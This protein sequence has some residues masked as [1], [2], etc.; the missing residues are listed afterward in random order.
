MFDA[1]ES[2]RVPSGG[3]Q[4]RAPLTNFWRALSTFAVVTGLAGVGCGSP[5]EDGDDAAS[6]TDTGS[7]VDGIVLEDS[8]GADA[9]ADSGPD[10]GDDVG[11][12]ATKPDAA[13]P[14]M[15]GPD[16]VGGGCPGNP[17]CT[18]IE[19]NDCD[20]SFCIDS[21]EGKVCAK[22]CVDSCEP[23]FKCTTVAGP[24]GDGQNICVAQWGKRC[25]PC[26][27]NADC[28]SIGHGDAV[29]VDQG[30]IGSFCGAGCAT[31]KD[32][33][34]GFACKESTDVTGKK[35]NQCVVTEG[36]CACS[37]AA[38]ATQATTACMV[39][40]GEA[41][42]PG[43]RT[44]LEKGAENAPA[45]GGLSACIA[46]DPEPEVCDGADND[47]DGQ[48]DEGTCDDDNVCTADVC[49][50]AGGCSHTNKQGACDADDSAC[51]EGD[52]C[53]DGLCQA[54]KTV[55]CND[56]N[57]CTLDLC[58]PEVGCVLEPKDNSPCDADDS[59]CTVADSC[60]AGACTVGKAK[61][62][63]T[64]DFCVLG[65]CDLVTG[66]CKFVYQTGTPCNDGN[67]CTS[68]ETCVEDLCKG[69]ALS[70]DDSNPCT[71]ESCDPAKG[72]EYGN[73][74]GPCDDGDACT[75]G[76]VCGDS[77][78]AGLPMDVSAAC[79]DLNACTADT[80]N[81]NSGCV[82]APGT[83]GECEDGN[84]CTTSDACKL[85]K[86]ESGSNL[87]TCTNDS[88]CAAK[89]DGN[90]CNGTLYC[91]KNDI[92]W[93]CKVNPATIVKCDGSIS[94]ACKTNACDSQT[95]KCKLDLAADGK[96]CDADE[97]LCTVGDACKSGNCTPGLLAK[98]DD[99]NPCT[100]DACDPKKGCTTTTNS[101][102]CDA[103]GD[104][105]TVGD[106]CTAGKCVVGSVKKDCDDNEPCTSESC[107]KST[108][109]CQVQKL[110]ISCDD[111]SLCTVGDA[112]AGDPKTGA[113]TCIPGALK[114]CGDNNP[115]TDDVCDGQKGCSNTNNTAPCDADDNACTA[116][117]K[118]VDG[119]C[120]IGGLPKDC[121]DKNQCT[122]D[123]CVKVTGD[124]A[125]QQQS[126]SC[127]DGDACTEGDKCAAMAGD[128][129][130]CVA[131]AAK[132]CDDGNV[133]TKDA[134]DPVKGCVSAID[135][136]TPVACYTGPAN[137]RGKG[138]CKDG[139]Q[140]CDQ[141]G[142]LSACKGSVLP[143]PK[144]LCNGLDD[145]CNGVADEGCKPLGFEATF[146]AASFDVKAGDRRVRGLVGADPVG[147]AAAG[148]K[149]SARFGF[150]AWAWSLIGG[151]Q[152]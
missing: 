130:G 74:P 26:S 143:G 19:A 91:D 137:T 55:D 129:W 60:A 50:G 58:K 148:N 14:D 111:G 125:H 93:T 136:K 79:D 82:H 121:D 107:V 57:V 4:A 21:P 123:A 81:P 53:V 100:N 147:G 150:A 145:D 39:V 124:C 62:C 34:A 18:C 97:S 122:A 142:Q 131:G 108:G 114:Q 151:K 139:A 24:G 86:C 84:P 59:P 152:P 35:S 126:K 3:S 88:E 110:T 119:V 77:K 27:E 75:K 41:K 116:G 71:A 20:S 7:Q 72:C 138:I 94:D 63:A 25:D 48:A 9:G 43:K 109:K 23:G 30:N 12:D 70:C 52:A 141:A 17:G 13:E 22:V 33:G 1:L 73:S 37:P 89:E 149:T 65:K 140:T 80:C 6:V 83:G 118:C 46:P 28:K 113:W 95:G 11:E 87:C 112:C 90:I 78:C 47:C 29:C 56:G 135:T 96:P 104:L 92:P 68:G 5:E 42:C 49:G 127:D 144:E 36:V 51:T 128:K 106:G 64:E 117:D 8:G 31:D 16:L 115:C 69:K 45:E 61:Q 76:D 44:C 10:A 54:G 103:D 105:C 38:I 32:C 15:V 146:G 134:C 66:K 132:A 120:K 85:G 101:S 102:P 98:C 67:A 99:A 2:E 40:A 133:C